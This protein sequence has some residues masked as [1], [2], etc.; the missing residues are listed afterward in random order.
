MS[1]PVIDDLYGC[2]GAPD[3]ITG[4]VY[5]FCG[6]GKISSAEADFREKVL[7]FEH[8]LIGDLDLTLAHSLKAVNFNLGV[9]NSLGSRL[10]T[11][12]C[13]ID[14][15]PAG[16]T[17]LSISVSDHHLPPG[18]YSLLLGV[19]TGRQVL[20]RQENLLQFALSQIGVDDPLLIPF[21]ARQRDRIG[22]FVPS[23]WSLTP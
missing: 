21:L 17:T 23:T 15:I 10:T 16:N 5:A 18:D 13:L 2:S 4:T 7:G 11:S 1:K 6:N 14:S 9:F 22:A 8:I 20:C 3:F 19:S 12:R